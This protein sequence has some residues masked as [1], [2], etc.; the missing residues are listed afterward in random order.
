[1]DRHVDD[2]DWANIPRYQELSDDFMS[3]YADRMDWSDLVRKQNMSETFILKHRSK[4]DGQ[5]IIG[6]LFN[7]QKLSDELKRQIIQ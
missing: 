3:A 5:R 6:L 7:H 2:L 1:M 4:W